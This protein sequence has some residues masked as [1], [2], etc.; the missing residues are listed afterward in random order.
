MA[1]HR[2]NQPSCREEE[3]VSQ[4]SVQNVYILT[5]QVPRALLK[6]S[7]SPS[8]HRHFPQAGRVVSRTDTAS[9]LAHTRRYHCFLNL[10]IHSV[11]HVRWTKRHS[12]TD[13][14]THLSKGE[15]PAPIVLVVQESPH[16][17]ADHAACEPDRVAGRLYMSLRLFSLTPSTLHHL[18]PP[19]EQKHIG[20]AAKRIAHQDNDDKIFKSN[21]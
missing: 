5:R 11:P 17:A 7:R 2:G 10:H 6:S 1:R 9:H 4:K 16:Q 21:L 15:P 19:H 8:A 14:Q 12:F 13:T 18:Y 20:R 3:R